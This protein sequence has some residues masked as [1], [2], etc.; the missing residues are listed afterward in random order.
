MNKGEIY[1]LTIEKMLYEGKSLSRLDDF[2]IFIE[3]GCPEDVVRVNII[4]VNKKYALGKIS[5]IITPSKHR[6]KPLC[7][8]HSVCGSCDWQ[9]IDYNEQLKQK[10]NIVIEA[11]HKE[12]KSDFPVNDV[13][14]SPKIKE[15]R[16]KVQY[17]VSQ[18]KVSKR[19]LS[20]YY[21][22]NSHELVNIKYCPVNPGIINEINEFLKQKCSELNISGYNELEHCG[23][24]KHLVYRISSD[25][26]R[27]LL[28]IVINSKDIPK[29]LYTLS[30]ILITEYPEI[31]GI[32]A[33][34][35]PKKTNVILSENTKSIAGD[36]FYIE[37]LGKYKYKISANSFFQ[38][39]PYSAEI[40]FNKI[41]EI[42]TSEIKKPSILDAYSGV[43]S[44]GIWLSEI[45]SKVVSVE[46]VKSASSDAKYNAAINNI[47]NLEIIN[48]D[49]EITFSEFIK[50]GICFDVTVIDPPRKGST[51][52]SLDYITKLTKKYLIYVSCN[53]NTLARDLK[54]LTDNGF[55]IKYIQPVDLFAHTYHIETIVVMK[56]TN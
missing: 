48:Q 27:I 20:G 51:N 35:N 31:K 55:E 53:P 9:N 33:N 36:D 23:L 29:E 15:Y 2:P 54:I 24:I 45:A 3:G 8:M 30:K 52:K 13:I 6:V 25:L 10:K 14:P 56:K 41:K 19:I 1:S 5:E 7:P 37:T 26:K 40:I 39:N 11:L 47:D 12:L 50:E 32:C 17:S 38:V 16:C 21:K 4:K 42:L 18:T 22:K 34:L 28:I 43:S 44:I 46:E 49:A